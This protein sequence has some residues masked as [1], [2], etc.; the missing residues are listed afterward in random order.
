MG[1]ALVRYAAAD[2]ARDEPVRAYC[3][4]LGMPLDGRRIRQLL[5]AY[6]LDAVARRLV[7][8]AVDPHQSFDAAW[9]RQ[10][11][12]VILSTIAED[13]SLASA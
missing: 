11:I 9:R 3:E 8:S 4:R 6:W 12:D 2:P 13:G 7:D 1:S 5:T 10:N